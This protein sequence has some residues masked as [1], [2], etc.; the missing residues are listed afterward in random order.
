MYSIE[1]SFYIADLIANNFPKIQIHENKKD[2][3]LF[4]VYFLIKVN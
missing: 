2:L 4:S 3:K 1:D